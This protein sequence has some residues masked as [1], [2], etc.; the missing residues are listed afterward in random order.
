MARELNYISALF[1][2]FARRQFRDASQ[3]Q[4]G[5]L[6]DPPAAFRTAPRRYPDE[7]TAAE[8]PHK[9]RMRNIVTRA[10]GKKEPKRTERLS[11]QQFFDAAR[12]NHH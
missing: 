4:N 9:L 5:K 2:A 3:M 10:I 8:N 6:L 1:F 11:V 7:N 12:R